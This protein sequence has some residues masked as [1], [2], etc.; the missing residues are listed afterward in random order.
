MYCVKNLCK[1]NMN[2]SFNYKLS[3][4]LCGPIR[5]GIHNLLIA[6]HFQPHVKAR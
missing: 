6:L 2:F 5:I 3:L 1:L 4:D